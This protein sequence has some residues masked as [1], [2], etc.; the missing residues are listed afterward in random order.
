[1]S[2]DE[3][4]NDGFYKDQ[5]EASY[6]S[7]KLV[8]DV[9]F[10]EIFEPSSVL[11]IGCGTGSWLSAASELGVQDIWGL[12]G[13]SAVVNHLMID[14]KN[15]RQEDLSQPI[16]LNRQF[17]LAMSLEVAEHINVRSHSHFVQ[18]LTAHS[19]IILFSAALPYQ[20]GT[21]HQSE[22]WPQYWQALFEE[23]GYDCYDIIRDKIWNTRGIQFWYKQNI[24]VFAKKSNRSIFNQRN[25][26]HTTNLMSMV[27]PEM[28]LWAMARNNIEQHN[29][30]QR[31]I[32]YYLDVKDGQKC[33]IKEPVEYGTEFENKF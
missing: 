7:A 3:F 15:W 18:N 27:H 30:Y 26:F 24:F 25:L 14:K 20:G 4:Y 5:A 23:E 12:D 22:N 8:L 33:A 28:Y 6:K 19:E 31:D 11:D 16:L 2:D 1:M 13:S 9:V 21:G 32:K 17:D 10:K 29:I